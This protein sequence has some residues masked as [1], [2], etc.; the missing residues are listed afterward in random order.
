MRFLSELCQQSVAMSPESESE[1]HVA[2]RVEGWVCGQ[3][4]VGSN[5]R[6]LFRPIRVECMRRGVGEFVLCW[7]AT[8]LRRPAWDQRSQNSSLAP[9]N[10]CTWA[11]VLHQSCPLQGGKEGGGK[12]RKGKRDFLRTEALDTDRNWIYPLPN[13]GEPLETIEF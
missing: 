13:D 3:L 10:T 12:E 11:A 4:P 7:S 1:G 5:R 9:L 6:W 2:N 8:Q